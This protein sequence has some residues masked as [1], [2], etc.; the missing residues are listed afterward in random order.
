[1]SRGAE[2]CNF[3]FIAPSSEE[4]WVLILTKC[5]NVV[6]VVTAVDQYKFEHSSLLTGKCYEVVICIILLFLWHFSELV[7]DSQKSNHGL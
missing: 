6:K 1:M 2:W 4:L 7:L 3:S 5:V